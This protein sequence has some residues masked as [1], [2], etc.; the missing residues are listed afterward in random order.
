MESLDP[1][2]FDENS[3]SRVARHG[4]LMR[5]YRRTGD[6]ALAREH[7]EAMKRMMPREDGLAVRWMELI[8]AQ[9][10]S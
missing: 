9:F 3:F 2:F 7:L 4:R 1:R 5:L 8:G 10:D 6:E